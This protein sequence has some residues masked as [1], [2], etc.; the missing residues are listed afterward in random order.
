MRP[1][2]D[3]YFIEM[4]KLVARRGTCLRRQVGC[5]LVDEFGHVLATGY[6][7]VARGVAHCNHYDPDTESQYPFAC[8]G[9]RAASGTDLHKCQAIHA[10]INALIQCT[11]PQDVFKVYTTVSPC[12]HC[13]RALLNTPAQEI[14]FAE[15][16]PHL[17]AE[18]LWVT[19]GR[20]WTLHSGKSMPAV[21]VQP[22]YGTLKASSSIPIVSVSTAKRS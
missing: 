16:Y 21:S 15:R 3:E 6:N 18:E 12:I 9:A 11:R 20:S 4:A 22:E 8:E 1:T 2:A 10:E 7:G 14:I 5:V 17:E 13:T 19:S